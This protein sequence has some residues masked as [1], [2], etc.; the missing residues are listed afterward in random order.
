MKRRKRSGAVEVW[1]SLPL[2]AQQEQEIERFFKNVSD[3]DRKWVESWEEYQIA[4]R[5]GKPETALEIASALLFGSGF[6][7]GLEYQKEV[8]R[9]LYKTFPDLQPIDPVVPCSNR[10]GYWDSTR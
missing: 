8:N 7:R 9:I 2:P 10:V 5:R 1:N 6:T 3:R 4:L